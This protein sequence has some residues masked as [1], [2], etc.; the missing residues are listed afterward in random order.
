LFDPTPFRYFIGRAAG[1]ISKLVGKVDFQE[2]GFWTAGV[3][4]LK[5]TLSETA[6]TSM[7][8]LLLQSDEYNGERSPPVL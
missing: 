8:E 1:C 4:E 7:G 5:E 3:P 2:R 6:D